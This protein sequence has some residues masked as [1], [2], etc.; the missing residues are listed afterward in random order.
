MH[1]EHATILKG[2][3]KCASFDCMLC[4][5]MHECST[6][7]MDIQVCLVKW[8]SLERDSVNMPIG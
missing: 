5:V 3:T 7:Y 6:E 2:I 1:K 4:C 8:W